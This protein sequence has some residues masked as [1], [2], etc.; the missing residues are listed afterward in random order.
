MISVLSIQTLLGKGYNDAFFLNNKNRY[1]VFAGARNTK[2][3]VDIIGIEPIIKIMSNEN[4]NICMCRQNDV[5]NNQSTFTNIISTIIRLNLTNYFTITKKPCLITYKPTGQVIIFRGMNNPTGIT[6]VK[7]KKGTLTDIYFE[8]AEELESYSDFRI[9]D[10]TL[11]DANHNLQITFVMNPYNKSHWIYSIFFKG[12]FEPSFD[13]LESHDYADFEDEDFTLGYGRGLYLHVSTYKINEFRAKY[14]DENMMILKQNGLELYKVEALG[15]WGNSTES[16][17]PEFSE[18]LVIGHDQAMNYNY[19]AYAIGIDTGL[20]NGEGKI[21]KG[22]NVKIHSA[23]T[24]QLV[25]L[26]S[27]YNNLIALNE[28]FYSN[29]NQIIKKTSP[30]L[31]NEIIDK[32]CEWLVLYKNKDIIMKGLV[33]IY[34]DCADIGF[35]QN[36]ENIAK[37][38]GLMNLCFQG[39]TKIRIQTRVDLIRLLMS[40]GEYKIT[41]LC[42]NLIREI[43]NCRQG[44]KGE[45]REDIN[46]HAINANEYAWC[47]LYKQLKRYGSFKEH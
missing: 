46:D 16:T 23:T 34:V 40:F 47:P 37:Q 32:L 43:R 17:Y 15:M 19:C 2:K 27:D 14:Y 26:T 41:N 29:E 31:A 44:D 28:Y 7:F 45:V 18:S 5:D 1:R 13:Y 11:R 30:Q 4:V 24:M 36:L 10:G 3:S 6:S 8:E 20:S 39:S 21:K 25:G 22:E 33:L 35:R 9:I 38:K 42:P 12:R